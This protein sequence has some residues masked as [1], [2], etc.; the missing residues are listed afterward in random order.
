ME[1]LPCQDRPEYYD[2]PPSSPRESH[3]HDLGAAYPRSLA[4]VSA[5]VHS[6]SG[7]SNRGR[8]LDRSAP[9]TR[10]D[11]LGHHAHVDLGFANPDAHPHPLKRRK[12]DVAP[13]LALVDRTDADAD[14]D[15]A[16]ARQVLALPAQSPLD[17]ILLPA[18]QHTF[19]HKNPTFHLLT[20]STTTLIEQE[21]E[22]VKHL[23]TACSRLRGEQFE[24]RWPGDDLR[25]RTRRDTRDHK[26]HQLELERLDRERTRKRERDAKLDARRR[27]RD[28]RR[29][30]ERERERERLQLVEQQRQRDEREQVER[31]R[32]DAEERD[33]IK[34]EP[35]HAEPAGAVARDPSLPEASNLALSMPTPSSL[36][37][38]PLPAAPPLPPPTSVVAPP[39][40]PP[41]QPPT[42]DPLPPVTATV[43]PA[44]RAQESDTPMEGVEP[45]PSGGGGEPGPDLVETPLA[46]PDSTSGHP[47]DDRDAAPKSSNAPEVAQEQGATTALGVSRSPPPPPAPAPGPDGAEPAVD[48]NAAEPAAAADA[49]AEEGEGDGGATA[50][51]E[52]PSIRRSG[53]HLRATAGLRASQLLFEDLAGGSGDDPDRGMSYSPDPYVSAIRGGGAAAGGGGGMNED[54]PSHAR[55]NEPED[56]PGADDDANN[57][58]DADGD[59]DGGEPDVEEL[60]LVPS[61]DIPEYAHRMV[62]PEAYVRSLFVTDGAVELEKSVPPGAP[63]GP[64]VVETLS[65]NEQEAL[66][67]DC[68]TDLHRFLSDTLEYRNRL[69]EIRD[70]I[71]EVERRR[72]GMWKVVRTVA[73]DWL[74][75]E[76]AG[77]GIGGTTA[78]AAGVAGSVGAGTAGGVV[79]GNGGAGVYEGYE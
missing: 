2:S 47:L 1:S 57:E 14:P 22:L 6:S 40:P 63:G 73:L 67:H 20:E 72:K 74:E 46:G 12:L 28:E 55:P 26:Q 15:L 18:I 48:G 61:E 11:K 78:A 68:L 45:G 16:P 33:R 10:A 24:W 53:R 60:A 4:A 59:D 70:G 52:E 41:P 44:D 7:G 21:G 8:K 3:P 62:D 35:D 13:N 58:D 37:S 30:R 29:E 31:E 79:N 50:A 54:E 27:E 36:P 25:E 39:S 49:P 5:H 65:R 23:A 51:A 42:V 56:H 69:S 17:L 9:F 76:A 43:P 77:G 75:E 66:V 32:Q 64:G 19:S 34:P 71:L 38:L